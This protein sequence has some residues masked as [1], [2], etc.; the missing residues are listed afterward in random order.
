MVG[1]VYCFGPIFAGNSYFF[2]SFECTVA[3]DDFNFIFLHQKLDT[4]THCSSNISA[5]VDNRI[6][7]FIIVFY[8]QSIVICMF[9]IF[10]DLSRF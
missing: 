8:G 10:K 6:K 1:F 5:S 3:H 4:F 7:I 2:T 9:E